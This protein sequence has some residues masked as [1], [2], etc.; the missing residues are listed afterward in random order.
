[1]E[2]Q[3]LLQAVATGA[4]STEEA[5]DE[6][7]QFP[8]E[9]LGDYACLD[10]HR[11]LRTGFPEVVYC[12]GKT[13]AQCA[14]IF[15]HLYEKHGLVLGTRASLAQFEAVKAKLPMAVYHERAR[16]ITVGAPSQCVGNVIVCTAGTSDI[17]V[18]EEAAVTAEM[19]GANVTRFY[20]MGVSGLHRILSRVEDLQKANAIIAIAGMEG[21]LASVIG[22]L[23]S[24]PVIAVPTSVGYGANFGGVSALLA[25]L[26]SCA[27]GTSVVNIDNGFGAGYLASQINRI[28]CGNPDLTVATTP[29]NLSSSVKSNGKSHPDEDRTKDTVVVLETNIDDT[30]GEQLGYAMEKLLQ[31]GA[32]DVW[33][34][35]IFMKKNRP[36]YALSVICS[37]EKEKLMQE[38]LFQQ[39][40]SIGLRRSV[41]ERVIMDREPTIIDTP[42]GPLAAKRCSYGDLEK[43]TVEFESAKELAE[44]ENISLLE[45]YKLF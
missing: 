45:L 24:N 8:F 9:N 6:L 43:I 39:T 13:T 33:F 19:C 42:Y 23:V 41:R 32:L 37:E 5:L 31:A 2:L 11:K 14:E 27:A 20:D 35:P 28:A 7:K 29:E 18:G 4:V 40:S 15:E 22:G 21:A 30:T 17:P 36:A 12:Q 44:K 34:V 3:E 26:N 1:M 38:I 25:M 16:C 10:T